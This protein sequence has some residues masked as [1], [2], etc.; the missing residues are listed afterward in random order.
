MKKVEL[1]ESQHEEFKESGVLVLRNFH[2][3][4]EE[5]R[6]IQR[7]IYRI[8]GLIIQKHD[9]DLQQ[10]AF[11]PET[12]DSCY[13]EL[14]AISRSYGSEVYDAVKQIPAFLRLISSGR[15][16]ALFSSVRG[17]DFAGIG[18]A[19][20]GIRIDSP[21]EEQ[22]R[23]QWHQEFLFQPQSS[24]G[25]V[26]WTPLVEVTPELGPVKVCLKSHKDGLR[27]CE[28]FGSYADKAGAYKIGLVDEQAIIAEYEQ[29]APLSKPGDLMIMDY[30]TLHASGMN[31]SDRARWSVQSRFF[32]FL[33]PVGIRLGWKPSVTVGTDIEDIFSDFFSEGK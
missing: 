17:T 22:F 6:P 11:T 24:D 27:K 20:Y 33:D 26:F 2:D 29:A 14:I 28:K 31:T 25:L 30:L 7:G 18:Q 12:F 5:I 8:I 9:L 16:E 32:N 10:S 13:S 19:S 3:V 1:T 21:G 23:S 4:E 15:S